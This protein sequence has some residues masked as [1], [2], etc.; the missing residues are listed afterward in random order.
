VFGVWTMHCSIALSGQSG[1][2]DWTLTMETTS[3]IP[4]SV[5]TCLQRMVNGVEGG[6]GDHEDPVS[7]GR[8]IYR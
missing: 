5:P 4:P 8:E 3:V 6:V 1:S 2:S 7:A